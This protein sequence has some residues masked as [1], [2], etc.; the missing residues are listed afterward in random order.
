MFKPKRHWCFLGQ[1]VSVMNFGRQSA[2]V[3]DITG[4]RILAAFYHDKGDFAIR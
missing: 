1:I 3:E 2:T 4:Q